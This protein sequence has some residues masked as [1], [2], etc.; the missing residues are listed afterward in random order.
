VR[1]RNL[2]LSAAAA[3]LARGGVSSRGG[4]HGF[5]ELAHLS[6]KIC[7]TS[8]KSV[9]IGGETAMAWR[10]GRGGGNK[11]SRPPGEESYRRKRLAAS[12]QPKSWRR[13]HV[14][15]RNSGIGRIWRGGGLG[16]IK[17]AWRNGGGENSKN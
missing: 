2:R 5:G 17:A 12:Q 6:E 9:S 4:E 1:H 3:G 8:G 10:A 7:K 15:R 13:Q 16:S 11:S 14:R